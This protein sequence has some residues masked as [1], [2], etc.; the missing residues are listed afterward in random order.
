MLKAHLTKDGFYAGSVEA[1][2][3]EGEGTFTPLPDYD[4]AKEV[5]RF[6]PPGWIVVP[7]SVRDDYVPS[8]PPPAPVPEKVSRRQAKKALSRAG[9]LADADDA[10][11]AM[12]G[13]AGEE[14][15]IDWVDAGDFRRDDPLIAGIGSKLG[16][17]AEAIDD[18]FRAAALIP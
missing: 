11:A 4:P 12:E 14:A 9:F 17:T 10:I 13:Q 15:R 16:L 8:A 5:P 7:L 3:I 2:F 6:V 1:D 18:L